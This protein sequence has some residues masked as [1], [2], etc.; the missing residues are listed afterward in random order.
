M[1]FVLGKPITDG[2]TQKCINIVVGIS[3]SDLDIV[4]KKSHM[5]GSPLIVSVSGRHRLK[6]VRYRCKII[7]PA[8]FRDIPT[9]YLALF[10]GKIAFLILNNSYHLHN[11]D[12]IHFNGR[13]VYCIHCIPYQHFASVTGNHHHKCKKSRKDLLFHTLFG[14]R[15]CRNQEYQRIH[16]ITSEQHIDNS[17]QEK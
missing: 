8:C 2:K 3:F 1:G 12:G 14:N 7:S 17:R 9:E 13:S 15:K 6:A 4:P 16:C 5:I 10:L 11:G